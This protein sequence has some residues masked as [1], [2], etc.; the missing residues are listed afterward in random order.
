MTKTIIHIFTISLLFACATSDSNKSN[1]NNHFKQLD[2]S[3]SVSGY[4]L[5]EDYYQSIQNFKSPKKAQ[6][7]SAFIF[8]P[9]RTLQQTTM[10]YNFHEGGPLLKV[11]KNNKHYELWEVVDDS[12]TQKLYIIEEISPTQI[13]LGKKV[14]YKINI[15]KHHD[16]YKISEAL[17]FKG[18]YTTAGG[19]TVEFKANG[20]LLGLD[21][22]TYYEPIIDYFDAGMQVDQIG[23]GNS[24]EK[25]TGYGFTFNRDTLSLYKLNCLTFDSTMNDCVEVGYGQLAY[26]LWKK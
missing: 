7:G 10:I 17:L 12:L 25:L 23:L 21:N 6:D 1:S 24:P 20:Q 14:F 13:K 2:T 22:F 8:I 19:K 4:W 9:N 11:L 26:K 3:V 16:T 18:K 15:E 5:S